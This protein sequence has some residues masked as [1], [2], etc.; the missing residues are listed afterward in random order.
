[1]S[2]PSTC[3]LEDVKSECRRFGR[4]TIVLLDRHKP[5]NCSIV[6]TQI[7]PTS[8]HGA[9][10]ETEEERCLLHGLLSVHH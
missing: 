2:G 5:L 6:Q 3:S 9:F 4:G 10:L 1:M 8:R 7:V